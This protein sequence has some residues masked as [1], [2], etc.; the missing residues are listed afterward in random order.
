MELSIVTTMYRSAAYLDEFYSRVR[1][2]A[3]ALTSDFEL[4]FVNDGSPDE[5]LAK[6]IGLY[7][8]DARV[9]VV[10]LARNFGHHKAI[11]AGLMHAQGQLVFYMDCDLEMDPEVMSE[12]HSLLTQTQA[13]VIYGVQDRRQDPIL[14]RIAGL[15]FYRLFNLLSAEQMPNNLLTTRLMTRRYVQALLSFQE[16]EMIIGGLWTLTGYRQVP[17][18][19][20]KKHKGTSTYSVGRRVTLLIDAIT[21]FSNRPLVLIFY[22]GGA[23]S[24]LAVVGGLYLMIRRLFF[25]VFLEGWPSLIVSIWM[26]GGLNILCLGVIGI[27][28]SKIFIETKKRPYVIVRDF[29]NH[30]NDSAS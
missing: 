28:L 9:R 11:M 29:Y 16:R 22:L 26:L 13:D 4:I 17:F 14:D 21:S 23:I 6:A 25:G 24:L 8:K 30:S 10:D 7:A 27:Y 18:I 12:M 15:M 20:Q 2:A 19:M 3:E 1:A 5:S